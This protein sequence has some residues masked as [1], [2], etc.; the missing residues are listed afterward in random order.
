MRGKAGAC[1]RHDLSKPAKSFYLKHQSFY[2]QRRTWHTRLVLRAYGRWNCKVRPPTATGNQDQAKAIIYYEKEDSS[3]EHFV[4]WV[5]A[6]SSAL[7]ANKLASAAPG[8]NRRRGQQHGGTLPPS[9]GTER[10]QGKEHKGVP[11]WLRVTHMSGTQGGDHREHPCGLPVS[12]HLVSC[13]AYAR[14]GALGPG[15]EEHAQLRFLLHAMALRHAN[16][17]EAGGQV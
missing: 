15:T 16:T 5:Q 10:M 11:T 3:I 12:T 2:W 1:T 8:V 9:A 7:A 14:L 17:P 6:A 4:D 13:S